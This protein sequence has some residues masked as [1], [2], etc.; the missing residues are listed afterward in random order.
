MQRVEH[1]PSD[2]IVFLHANHRPSCVDTVDKPFGYHTVQLMTSGGVRLS[3][4]HTR[5]D[6]QGSWLWPCH[7]GPRIRFHEWPRGRPWNHRHLAVSGPRVDAWEA[8]DLWPRAPLE[9]ADPDRWADALD[10]ITAHAGRPERRSRWRAAALLEV[11]LLDWQ[12]LAG[13]TDAA[14]P[15]WLARTMEVIRSP[16]RPDY[17]ALADSLGWS[18]STLQRRFRQATGSGLHEV[19]VESRI[20]D[21]RRLLGETDRPIKQIAD[22]LGYTDVF[23]FSRQFTARVG[24]PPARYRR[25]RLGTGGSGSTDRPTARPDPEL[26]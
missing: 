4:D 18:L 9:V 14:R 19:H 20:M 1:W 6:L 3:Y 17:R 26:R 7:P 15:A 5:H 12:E 21:A 10:E 13:G 25:E 8:A 22:G 2:G 11:F 23:Y 24:M 16:G